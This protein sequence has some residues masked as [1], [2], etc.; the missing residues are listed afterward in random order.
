MLFRSERFGY[1]QGWV[2]NLG[3]CRF[4]NLYDTSEGNRQLLVMPTWRN[5]ISLPTS[6]SYE[7]E[8]VNN[9]KE[10]LYYQNWIGLL[11]SKKLHH[12]LEEEHIT[13][14]FYPHRGMQ[15]YLSYFKLGYPNIILAKW[16]EYDVQELLKES[17]L[18]ITDYS[19]IAMD[20]AYMEKPLFYYQFDYE[21]FRR[22][23][24]KEGYFN[25][26][27]D[28][29][30]KVCGNLDDLLTEVKKTLDRDFGIEDK[31]KKRSNDFFGNISSNNCEK[32]YLAIRK[33]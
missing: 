22:G 18:L 11:Q 17:N 13:L 2:Q 16:P 33:I 19:S 26:Q 5:W 6:R 9:F 10:T 8:D 7:M 31:Y 20:F 27:K 28:G 29:F 3:F 25:Y 30:G 32:N 14:V 15:K 4:D 21:M 1:P 24:Y 23:Q 12:L